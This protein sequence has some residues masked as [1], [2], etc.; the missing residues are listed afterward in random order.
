[1]SKKLKKA[2]YLLLSAGMGVFL[3]ILFHELGHMAVML[4]AGATITDFSIFTAH[5]SGDGGDYTNL[6]RMCRDASGALLPLMI[7][8]LYLLLYKKGS[9]KSFYRI[10]SYV[11]TLIPIVSMLAWVFIPFVYLQGNA[12]VKDDVTKFLS[13]FC[14]KYHPLIVSAAAA[15]LIGVG[16]VLMIKKRVIFHF[17]E[18]IRQE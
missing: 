18:E 16:V 12:P 15:A 3:Y 2:G 1:M 4:S 8:Y 5:V 11:F 9:T 13:V 7:S 6:S 14:E 17:M 10:F